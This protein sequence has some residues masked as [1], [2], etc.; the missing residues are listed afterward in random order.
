M[1]V[2]GL[3]GPQP[4]TL[5]ATNSSRRIHGLKLYIPCRNS[6]NLLFVIYSH[7]FYSVGIKFWDLFPKNE[8][9]DKPKC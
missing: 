7:E 3:Q 4:T 5:Q 2:N 6:R 1:R 9:P 8:D